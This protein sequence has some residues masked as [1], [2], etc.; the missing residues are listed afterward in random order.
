MKTF[1]KTEAAG[2]PGYPGDPAASVFSDNPMI[3]RA[4]ATPFETEGDNGKPCARA[5]G[6][7]RPDCSHIRLAC[8]IL[9]DWSPCQTQPPSAYAKREVATLAGGCF[10][11]LDA[12]FRELRGVQEVVSG[13]TGG[14]T[15][16][17]T[18]Y[19]VGTGATGHAGC[20][21]GLLRSASH[22]LS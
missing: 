22:R 17:P 11:C 9:K 8:A 21:A 15:A 13:Y 18:Y 12:T 14:Q 4:R 6:M 7:L 20:G 3:G 16:N 1:E 10:W 5:F 19:A 2:S